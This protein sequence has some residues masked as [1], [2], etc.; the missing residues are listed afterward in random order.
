MTAWLWLLLGL[1]SV[2]ALA[3]GLYYGQLK[4]T[5]PPHTPREDRERD[6]ATRQTYEE[7]EEK[8]QDRAA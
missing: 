5:H 3:A 4:S 7:I 8:R 2:V 6:R 1:M